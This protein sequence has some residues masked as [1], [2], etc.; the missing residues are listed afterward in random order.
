MFLVRGFYHNTISHNFFDSL[1]KCCKISKSLYQMKDSMISV[2]GRIKKLSLLLLYKKPYRKV[3]TRLH[4]PYFDR[5]IN[6]I[7]VTL[8]K[9]PDYLYAVMGCN[10]VWNLLYMRRCNKSMFQDMLYK[11]EKHKR[12]EEKNTKI[13]ACHKRLSIRKKFR[14]LSDTIS[15]F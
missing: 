13:K 6:D 7:D 15:S 1:F 14:L 9:F 8:R 2:E 11:S 5:E 10:V 12:E 3:H 4:G